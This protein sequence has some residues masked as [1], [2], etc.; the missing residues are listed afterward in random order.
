MVMPGVRLAVMIRKNLSLGILGDGICG[1]G[2][3]VNSGLL[4]LFSCPPPPLLRP[5]PPPPPQ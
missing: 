5:P 2:S 1:V 3:D 4:W